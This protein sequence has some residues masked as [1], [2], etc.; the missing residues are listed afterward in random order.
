MV[1]GQLHGMYSG[2]GSPISRCLMVRGQLHGMYSGGGS[3][4]SRCLMVRGQLHGVPSRGGSPF[5]KN[6]GVKINKMYT[7]SSE[8]TMCTRLH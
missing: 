2:G 8:N 5:S 3:P 1:R 6:S 4:I 7:T